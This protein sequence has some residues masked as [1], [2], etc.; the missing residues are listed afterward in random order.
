MCLFRG[1]NLMSESRQLPDNLVADGLGE[2]NVESFTEA[3][4]AELKLRGYV[5]PTD[6][7]AEPMAREILGYLADEIDE[8]KHTTLIYW[9]CDGGRGG[10]DATL[11]V[12]SEISAVECRALPIK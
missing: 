6:N 9:A 7:I 2:V 5:Q 1:P 8:D 3:A 10:V 11:E 12:V 4:V